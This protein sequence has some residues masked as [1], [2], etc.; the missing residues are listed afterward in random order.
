[1]STESERAYQAIS[2]LI[3]SGD[4]R[5]GERIREASLAERIG[6][7]R[8]PVRE[9]LRRLAAEGTV[10]YEPNRGATLSNLRSSDV[11]DIFAVRALLEPL[12]AGLAAERAAQDSIGRLEV[13]YAQMSAEDALEDLDALSALNTAFHAEI[14]A[15]AD[16]PVVRDCVALVTRRSLV[17]QTFGRYSPEQHRRSQQQHR[18]IIDAIVTHN[19]R[20]A[21]STMQAHIEAG[22]EA[23]LGDD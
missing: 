19:A 16:S 2:A 1:V 18:D 10:E 5:A 3:G 23:F 20:W 12:A 8:T 15:A 9:A 13:L 17:R 7:S 21:E 6:V 11:R 14:L 22:R 4:I